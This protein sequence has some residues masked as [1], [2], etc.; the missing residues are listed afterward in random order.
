MKES[1]NLL[2][3]ALLAVGLGMNLTSCKE[4]EQTE[5]EKQQ[6]AE[7][8]LAEAQEWWDV[9]SQLTDVEDFPADWQ[10][11]TFEP[12]VG[13]ASE[14]DPY[15]RVIA[16]NDLATAAQRFA[17]LTGAAIDETTAD[18][19]W[20][21][22]NAGSLTYHAGSPAG[23]YLAQV[24]VDLK[25][26][27]RLKKILYQTPDQMGENTSGSFSGSAYY[28]FGDVVKKINSAGT[29]DYWVCVRPSF[30]P[31]RKGDSHWVS[32][33]KLPKENIYVKQKDGNAWNLPT[34]LGESKEHM[35][36][37]A[38]MMYAMLYPVQYFANLIQH[39]KLKVFHDFNRD[40]H[41]K[42]HNQ[43]FWERVCYAWEREKIFSEVFSMSKDD[44]DDYITTGG[45]LTFLY[46]GY[47]WWT[48]WDLSLWQAH[49]EGPNLKTATYTTPSKDMHGVKF[50]AAL[51]NLDPQNDDDGFFDDDYARYI[52]R[53]ATGEKLSKDAN[54]K[55]SYDVKVPLSNCEDV[56][57]YNKYFYPGN[58]G[59]GQY[60]L[61]SAPEVTPERK[62]TRGFFAP[63]TVVRDEQKRLWICYSTWID[64][65]AMNIKSD[66]HKT[67][68]I[69]FNQTYINGRGISEPIPSSTKGLF[70]RNL[71][72]ADEV[73]KL[74][75]MLR[76]AAFPANHVDRTFAKSLQDN[77]GINAADLVLH[78]DSVVNTEAGQATASIVSLNLA[79]DYR[80]P[81]ILA[82][83]GLQPYCRYITDGTRVAGNRTNGTTSYPYHYFYSRY[84][85]GMDASHPVYNIHLDV[86]HS[87]KCENRTEYDGRKIENFEVPYD[88]WS[89]CKHH[90]SE[91]RDGNFTSENL[92][93]G[94]QKYTWTDYIPY[95][96]GGKRYRTTYYEPV[97]FVAY[98]EIDDDNFDFFMRKYNSYKL[99]LVA[100]PMQETEKD[101]NIY[102]WSNYK[103]VVLPYLYGNERYIGGNTDFSAWDY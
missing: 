83:S 75:L 60:D 76:A 40:D 62:K 97:T 50:N 13:K 28:R 67:R 70:A 88:R 57:V 79:Y 43:Y 12:A 98:M 99:T 87:F 78:R 22:K 6:Q 9:V 86:T 64:N 93:G 23:T 61:N 38:E 27:P 47:S 32:L 46:K 73:I 39:P 80:D 15:T 85:T 95:S 4:D 17:Y 34:K 59:K 51:F 58:D 49:Y 92:F 24:D 54:G 10:T 48:G 96:T 77:L 81:S 56:Y 53:Y 72:P 44:I 91:Q 84:V 36:N 90:D 21:H 42:Y 18:Y 37:F 63:G 41:G 55:G 69:S 68:F 26:M 101:Q 100:D 30:S 103:D 25:Q 16:T 71:V 14:N 7:Q 65:P 82:N 1:M 8:A 20:K 89:H 5:E 74:A 52:I 2:L 45:G 35:Q 3:M 94:S 31:E 29:Y 19:T 11:A 66:D 33:S 102:F